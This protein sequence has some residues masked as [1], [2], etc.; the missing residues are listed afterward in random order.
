MNKY[1]IFA[2]I[3]VLVIVGFVAFRGAPL[4]EGKMEKGGA[5]ME[6]LPAATGNVDDAVNAILSDIS[7]DIAPEAESDPTLTQ[8][9]V[10]SD[11]GASLDVQL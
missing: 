4:E 3:V 2:I 11:F 9:D 5:V 10:P 7:G 8:S 6:E 1:I